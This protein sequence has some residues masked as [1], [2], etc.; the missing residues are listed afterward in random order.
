MDTL[1]RG[2][3]ARGGQVW[4]AKD[5]TY[6]FRRIDPALQDPQLNALAGLLHGPFRTPGGR[7]SLTVCRLDADVPVRTLLVEQ[8]G[9]P[10]LPSAGIVRLEHPASEAGLQLDFHALP[11]RAI[12]RCPRSAPGQ[13]DVS[14]SADATP[15]CRFSLIRQSDGFSGS[16]RCPGLKAANGRTV[17][18]TLTRRFL[19]FALQGAD[20]RNETLLHLEPSE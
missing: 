16:G 14:V 19:E 17:E 10:L 15:Y 11:A 2:F 13:T 12:G 6:R 18:A 3:D 9:L 20:G 1:D 4:G 5:E 7:E 8:S